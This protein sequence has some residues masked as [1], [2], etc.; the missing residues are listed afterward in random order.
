MEYPSSQGV[1]GAA[2]TRE[3]AQ[4]DATGYTNGMVI[5]T[6]PRK[7]PPL[8]PTVLLLPWLRALNDG[9]TARPPVR[10]GPA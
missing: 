6:M 7:M 3:E 9:E 4:F 5:T 10:E 8:P 1:R 2:R